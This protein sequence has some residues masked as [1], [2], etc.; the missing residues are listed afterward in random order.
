MSKVT[1][2]RDHEGDYHLTAH[3]TRRDLDRIQLTDF[4]NLMLADAP[5]NMADLLLDAELIARRIVEA[6]KP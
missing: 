5:E 1:W 3:F 4:D 6:H 2:W